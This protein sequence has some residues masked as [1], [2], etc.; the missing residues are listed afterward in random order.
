MS[1]NTLALFSGGIDSIVMARLLHQSDDL[2]GLF[3]MDFG[4]LTFPRQLKLIESYSQL[5][6]VPYYVEQYRY[7]ER[8]PEVKS[9]GIFNRGAKPEAFSRDD[10]DNMAEPHPGMGW[11]HGRNAL[12]LLMGG[13]RAAYLGCNKLAFGLQLSD[14]EINTDR[15]M[16]GRPVAS[17]DTTKAFME[18]MN[19]VLMQ[20][21]GTPVMIH[22]PLL[23]FSKK[24]V[25]SLGFTLNE[26]FAE[27]SSCEYE[28]ACGVCSQCQ[29]AQL[30][31]NHRV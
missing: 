28:P 11:L 6:G 22:A 17:N 19:V 30:I 4:Q 29:D 8:F 9:M 15:S 14:V 5:L 1:K 21:C 13:I 26:D 24:Q 31:R 2:A 10:L 18:S 7:Q 12:F 23:G 25:I 20:T 27:Y 3:I 16:L